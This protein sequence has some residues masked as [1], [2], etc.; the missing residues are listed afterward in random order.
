ME[1]NRT[2][3]YTI[4]AYVLPLLR[5]DFPRMTHLPHPILS[6]ILPRGRVFKKKLASPHSPTFVFVHFSYKTLKD[7]SG[8]PRLLIIFFTLFKYTFHWRVTYTQ[9]SKQQVYRSM[10]LY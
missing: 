9:K 8:L 5:R 3:I 2:R 4:G 10:N 1:T 7:R 6:L